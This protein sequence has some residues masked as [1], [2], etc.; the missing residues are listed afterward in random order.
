MRHEL[1]IYRFM[2]YPYTTPL[3]TTHK[4]T[5]THMYRQ[6]I[7]TPPIPFTHSLSAESVWKN[8]SPLIGFLSLICNIIIILYIQGAVISSTIQNR[9]V[10]IFYGDIQFYYDI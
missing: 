1:F 4:H 2:V 8:R 6:V 10:F 9:L 3:T 5:H 7:F